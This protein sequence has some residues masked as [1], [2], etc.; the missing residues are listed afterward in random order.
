MESL[1]LIAR[2]DTPVLVAM[3]ARPEIE[4]DPQ[5]LPDARMTLTGLARQTLEH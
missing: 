1:H 5:I 4:E 2:D 3:T